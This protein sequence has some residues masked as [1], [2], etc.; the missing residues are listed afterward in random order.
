MSHIPLLAVA[1]ASHA[2][3]SRSD[4]GIPYCQ[5]WKFSDISASLVWCTD[6]Q[7]TAEVIMFDQPILAASDTIS[8]DRSSSS[9]GPATTSTST[10][11]EEAPSPTETSERKSGGMSSENTIALGVAIRAAV[12][13]IV[14][15]ILDVWLVKRR[16]RR[17]RA[18]PA[19]PAVPLVPGAPAVI[20]SGDSSS[21]W[22]HI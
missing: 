13:G 2:P 18:L 22:V 6:V 7:P 10:S 9:T 4:S 12:T 19:A 16:R 8:T 15:A 1:G 17:M 11:T 21:G 20:S 5:T 3:S 14:S